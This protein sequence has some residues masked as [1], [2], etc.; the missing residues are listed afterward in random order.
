[1]AQDALFILDSLL[2]KEPIGS[3]FADHIDEKRI[4]MFGHSLGGAAALEVCRISF[5]FKACADLDGSVWGKVEMEGVN[6][7]YLVL[8]NVPTEARRPPAAIRKQRDDEW[9]A[10]VSKKKTRSFIVKI[11][12][13]FHLSF[14]DIP[15]IVPK[16]LLEKHGADLPPT[17]GL[18]IITSVLD[19]FFTEYL[20]DGKSSPFKILE[21]YKEVAIET[22]HQ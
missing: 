21:Q 7:P 20:N 4:G 3:R 2:S 8:L 18:E 22:Y 6:L 16:A 9:A 19:A 15:F 13:T 5:R 17:R 11:D 12:G 10:V 14:S 1:M